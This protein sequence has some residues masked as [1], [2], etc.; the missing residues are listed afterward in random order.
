MLSTLIDSSILECD[1]GR[2]FIAI[3]HS[4]IG[5]HTKI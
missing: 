4:G 2:A 5:R 3:A 1:S